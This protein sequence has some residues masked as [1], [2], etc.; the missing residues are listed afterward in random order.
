MGTVGFDGHQGA[1]HF[2]FTLRAAL[3]PHKAMCNAPLQGLVKTGFEMKAID[4]LQR[5]PVAPIGHF[6][7]AEC[8]QA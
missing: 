4:P 2:V 5:P 8:D 6:V 7:G 1:R 3:K